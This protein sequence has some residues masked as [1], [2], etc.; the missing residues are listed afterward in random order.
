MENSVRRV[1][2]VPERVKRTIFHSIKRMV[3]K[4]N[5][6]IFGGYVRDEIISEYYTKQFYKASGNVKQYWDASQHPQTNARI[7][8][9][10]D[11]D[12]SFSKEEDSSAFIEDVKR[13]F[14]FATKN[15]YEFS[16]EELVK[17]SEYSHNTNI[18]KSVRKLTFIIKLGAIPFVFRGYDMIICI[19]V[20]TPYQAN[21][22]PPFNNLDFLCNAFIMTK[23]GKLIS[24]CTGTNIDQLCD[25]N[26]T[27]LASKITSDMLEFKTYLCMGQR[28]GQCNSGTFQYN[29]YVLK[30]IDK[31]LA[32]QPA[33]TIANLPF[34]VQLT[35]LT[36][37]SQL[38]QQ[39]Q[40]MEHSHEK[41]CDTCCICCDSFND[42]LSSKVIMYSEKED[43][44]KIKGSVSHYECLSKYFKRQVEEHEER[45]FRDE[46]EHTDEFAFRCPFRNPINFLDSAKASKNIILQYI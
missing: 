33:W 3:F 30:R 34:T 32:K 36:E 43:K 46:V 39:A 28:A 9:A 45:L 17:T 37:H 26:K 35:Q 2:I 31:L 22:L 8:N 38:T 7:L 18:I 27:K 41:D 4:H 21:L 20:V 16:D 1:E 29:K 10:D 6:V 40:L 11:M 23:Y 19:D 15:M 24:S 5:G 14:E 44:T 12:V 42:G 25:V 13:H